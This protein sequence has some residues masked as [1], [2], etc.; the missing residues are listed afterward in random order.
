MLEAPDVGGTGGWLGKKWV[1]TAR[2]IAANP[3]QPHAVP[4]HGACQ[5]VLREAFAETK[6][7]GKGSPF[8]EPNLE[9]EV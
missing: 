3:C 6:A 9:A 5:R 2:S 4:V 1:L 8:S 7:E